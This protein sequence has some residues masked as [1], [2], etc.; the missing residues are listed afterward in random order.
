[1]TPIDE[2]GRTA[3]SGNKRIEDDHARLI[4]KLKKLQGLSEGHKAIGNEA[5]AQ[6]FAD[7]FQT[8]LM[9]HKLDMTD[10]EF[11]KLDAEEPVTNN[12]IDFSQHPEFEVKR[13]PIQW[14]TILASIIADAHYCQV[15][16]YT[17][18]NRFSLVG[19]KSDAA[20]AEYAIITLI[21]AAGRIATKEYAAYYRQCQA[22]GNVRRARGFR[23]AFLLGFI[24]R[25]KERYDAK[26]TGDGTSTALVRI[27]RERK[28]VADWMSS[29]KEN[30]EVRDLTSRKRWSMNEAGRRRGREL[31][32]GVDID[33]KAVRAG[34][35][36]GQ[37]R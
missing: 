5:E 28:A 12:D 2:H 17:G 30:K 1:M 26:K 32:D 4:D 36:Q 25:L 3:A 27:A 37:L 9:R 18:S 21:R 14:Q 31:A 33:G 22:E 34:G 24:N 7:M 13:S 15:L 23:D 10:I 20:V 8:L 29:A 19:R 16:R 11:A 6:A 35:P